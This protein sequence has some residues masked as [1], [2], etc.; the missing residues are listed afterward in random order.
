MDDEPISG[1]YMTWDDERRARFDEARERAATAIA[2]LA[3]IQA[4]DDFPND[5]PY[6]Q[7]WIAIAEWTNVEF[8]RSN[9]GGR[10]IFTPF[11]QMLSVGGGL[12]DWARQRHL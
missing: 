7:G 5:P 12:A 1:G 11:G 8:E 10:H 9:S 4:E 2:D 6:V 3:R